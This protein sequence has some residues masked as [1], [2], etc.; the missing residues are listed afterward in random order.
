[1]QTYRVDLKAASGVQKRTPKKFAA[2][3]LLYITTWMLTCLLTKI[4]WPPFFKLGLGTVAGIG[5]LWSLSMA[6]FGGWSAKYIVGDSYELSV[7]NDCLTGKTNLTKH[8]VRRGEVRTVIERSNGLAVS[9][10]NRTG[11]YLWGWVWIPRELPEYEQLKILAQ[12]WKR[13]EPSR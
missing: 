2:K 5:V 13:P 11:T 6:W 9:C 3:F 12:S 10:R 4:L 1:V 8:T 7:S